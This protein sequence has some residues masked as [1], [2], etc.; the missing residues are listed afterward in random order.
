MIT[1]SLIYWIGRMESIAVASSLIFVIST[2]LLALFGFFMPMIMDT[3][4]DEDDVAAVK[5]WFKR[6][7]FVPII[8]GIIAIF[9]PNAKEVAAMVVLPRVANSETVEQLGEG[10]RMLA[11]EWME[12]LRPKKEEIK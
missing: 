11:V 5:K 4:T 2:T 9:T 6:L 3:M 8:S 7:L 10:V 1:P 12:E